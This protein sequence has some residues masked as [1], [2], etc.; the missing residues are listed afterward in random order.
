M[1]KILR[2]RLLK[3]PCIVEGIQKKSGGSGKKFSFLKQCLQG[4]I[5]DKPH[6]YGAVHEQSGDAVTAETFHDQDKNGNAARYGNTD[7]DQLFHIDH[8]SQKL[9]LKGLRSDFGI[10]LFAQPDNFGRNLH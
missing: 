3:T 5:H 9:R 7:I 1:A 4:Y 10:F 8:L 6:T 2:R